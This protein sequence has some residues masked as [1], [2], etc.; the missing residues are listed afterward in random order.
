MLRRPSGAMAEP[1]AKDVGY[2]QLLSARL[3]A[4]E[5]GNPAGTSSVMARVEASWQG[6]NVQSPLAKGRGRYEGMPFDAARQ[7]RRVRAGARIVSQS[8][9]PTR[10]A[11]SSVASASPYA[12]IG[13]N[14]SSS[15]KALKSGAART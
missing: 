8:S 4:R 3:H 7:E 2:E 10:A 5:G 15:R 9:A 6:W 11:A 13:T 14:T 1:I 12:A